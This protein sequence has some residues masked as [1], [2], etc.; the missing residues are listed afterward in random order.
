[1]NLPS[2][3]AV[4]LGGGE[5]TFRLMIVHCYSVM[6]ARSKVLD[7]LM[8]HTLP[9]ITVLSAQIDAKNINLLDIWSAELPSPRCFID[10]W[11]PN[12]EVLGSKPS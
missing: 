8:S 9:C 3:K 2:I 6:K 10:Q 12:R 4:L 11:P 1:M 7:Q 5:R